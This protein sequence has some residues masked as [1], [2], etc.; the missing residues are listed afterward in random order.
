MSLYIIQSAQEAKLVTSQ[1]VLTMDRTLASEYGGSLFVGFAACA[2]KLIPDPL[3]RFFLCPSV[4]AKEHMAVAAPAGTRKMEAALSEAGIDVVV[5]HPEHLE[6]VIGRET[7]VVGIT[8]NDPRG[9]GPASSTFSSLLER[10]TFSALFFEQTVEKVREILDSN[11]GGKLVVGGPGAWQLED[12][13]VLDKYGIDCVIIGEGEITGVEIVK[14]ALRGEPIPRVVHGEMV[15]LE[16]IPNIKHR[17]IGGLIEISRG[18]GR[19][20]RFCLPNLKFLRS[21][22]LHQILEEVKINLREGS[23]GVCLHAEDVLRYGAKGPIPDE[24]KVIQLFEQ[25]SKLTPHVWI[26][27]FAFASVACRPDLIRKITELL[28]SRGNKA[29]WY[30]GQVGIE[31]ASP[32][33]VKRYMPGK[34]LPFKPEEWSEVVIRAHEILAENRWVPCSTLISGLPGET[35]Q[36]VELTIELVEKL[37]GFKS[38]IVPLFFVP[39]GQLNGGQ[40]FLKEHMLPE[41][42][43]LLATCMEHDFKWA[44]K[45]AEE[46]LHN[47]IQKFFVK[48]VVL[49]SF[50]HQLKGPLRLMKEGIDPTK[51][52]SSAPISRLAPIEA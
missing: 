34:P 3:Y 1:V 8:S 47:R 41:H 2:P 5:A 29:P 14:R 51:E 30:S 40:F 17:T 52:V 25:V 48:E 36:D 42:W 44:P 7:K 35:P 21:R 28:D 4:E 11:G 39:I 13:E 10:K 27:H 46:H 43:K 33:L 50:R 26:S 32:E 37:R 49:R 9:F 16:R 24:T 20:C 45:L 22:P 23:E 12:E 38:L 19:G 15:P 18:C 6:E 31:T